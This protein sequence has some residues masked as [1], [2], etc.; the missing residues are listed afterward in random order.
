MHLCPALVSAVTW[1]DHMRGESGQPWMRTHVRPLGE[2][3]VGSVTTAGSTRGG[4]R[5]FIVFSGAALLTTRKKTSR[6]G[7]HAPRPGYASPR[8][9]VEY[10]RV[11]YG[12]VEYG[13]A[14]DTSRHPSPTGSAR[15][16]DPRPRCD[17]AQV[18]SLGFV[19]LTVLSQS[20]D[21][22]AAVE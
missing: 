18:R 5:S 10:G 22:L 4:D 1:E 20:R 3:D 9:R 13:R 2:R 11:E 6:H 8:G 12:R 7:C 14:A 15:T 17:G 16:V 19:C 21:F